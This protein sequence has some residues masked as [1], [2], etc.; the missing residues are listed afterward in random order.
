[1]KCRRCTEEINHTNTLTDAGKAEVN[2]SGMC[3]KC[4]DDITFCI[5]T[6]KAD[7]LFNKTVLGLLG[8]G[9]IL[10]GGALR[11]F[12]DSTDEICDYDL[13]FTAD[14]AKERVKEFLSNETNGFTKIF[15]CPEGKL[16]SFRHTDGT[17]VQMIMKREYTNMDDIIGSFDITACCAAWD[18]VTF[19]RHGR[20][21]FDIL[22]K[23]INLNRVEYPKATMKRIM[24]YKDKGYTMTNSCVEDF[25]HSVNDINLTEENNVFYID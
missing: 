11:K 15:E 7:K 14:T 10:A 25:V 5:E 24:K 23:Q 20:F 17:K 18:G 16:F 22:N 2:V 13:F 12:V 1:M 21:V 6:E 19:L 8:D 9:C 4:F 3:E